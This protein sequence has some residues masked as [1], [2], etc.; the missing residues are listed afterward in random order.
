MNLSVIGKACL[1]YANDQEDKLPPDLQTLVKEGNLLP[2]SLESK[3][4][5]MPEVKPR[6]AAAPQAR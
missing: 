3:R 1:L 5:P 2:T 4:K 6:P